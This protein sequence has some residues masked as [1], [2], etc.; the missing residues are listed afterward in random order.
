MDEPKLPVSSSTPPEFLPEALECYRGVLESLREAQIPY[1]VAGTFALH[2][3][4]GIWRSIR[5][6]DVVLEPSFVPDALQCL[7]QA[8]FDTYIEDPVW[9]A[10]AAR[11]KHFVDLISGLGNAALVVDATWI[12]RAAPYEIFGVPCRVLNPEEVI[13]SKS[14]VTRRERFDG[15]DV[16]HLIRACGQRMDWD[17]LQRLLAP[18]WGIL[19]WYLMF[20]SYVY[21]AHVDVIPPDV[22]SGLI[23]RFEEHIHRPN[24]DEPFRGS[25]VDPNMFAIDV[26]EWGEHD[27]YGEYCERHPF[28]SQALGSKDGSVDGTSGI[29]ADSTLFASDSSRY[30]IGQ[31][32]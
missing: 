19:L 6:L 1:A 28:L 13:V 27:L 23:R 3:H 20:F 24:K 12:D 17:R 29:R 30:K 4:T 16:A 8:G 21:P 7:Q 26:A 9:L 14:F 25:I 32:R 10:K 11:G 22:W 5:D 31:R 18:H 2:R 15:A